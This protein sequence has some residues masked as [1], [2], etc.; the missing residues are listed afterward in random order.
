[1]HGHR[2][3]GHD[4]MQTASPGSLV[5]FRDLAAAFK[6]HARLGK[7]TATERLQQVLRRESGDGY[8]HA[9]EL[10]EPRSCC[11]LCPWRLKLLGGL[12]FRV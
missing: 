8:V 7:A 2:A 1:M 4:H 3:L 11:A 12:G 9:H 10:H 5:A 6:V